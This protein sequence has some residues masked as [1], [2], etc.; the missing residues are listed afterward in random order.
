MDSDAF[1]NKLDRLMGSTYS[2]RSGM[3]HRDASILK[4]VMADGAYKV[5]Q[6]TAGE[7]QKIEILLKNGKSIVLE[8]E[9]SKATMRERYKTLQILSADNAE[10]ASMEL[11]ALDH[12][13]S[14]P[15]YQFFYSHTVLGKGKGDIGLYLAHEFLEELSM[16]ERFLAGSSVDPEV[17]KT[18]REV[19][20]RKNF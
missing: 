16:D 10:L 17:V 14:N 9:I 20:E 15:G 12:I 6:D 7:Y 11:I 19:V 1:K 13:T 18:I 8:K 3:G 2:S 4:Q 5:F